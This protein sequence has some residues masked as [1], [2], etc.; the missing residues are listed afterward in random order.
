MVQCLLK[1]EIKASTPGLE[2]SYGFEMIDHSRTAPKLR[3][4]VP[5]SEGLS[6]R[7]F[8]LLGTGASSH[9]GT[10]RYSSLKS[11]S[12]S[13]P[14]KPPAKQIPVGAE[15]S[16]GSKS[17]LNSTLVEA[18]VP[19]FFVL[20]RKYKGGDRVSALSAILRGGGKWGKRNI[21]MDPG[22]MW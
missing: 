11:E 12:F 1:W 9:G 13:S 14:G 4:L 17:Q 20:K 16:L 21:I 19:H 15:I 5:S 6:P 3:K 7:A 18:L 22:S 8:L 10:G 2:S